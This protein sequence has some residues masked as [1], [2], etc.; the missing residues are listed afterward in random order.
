M[1]SFT[2]QW[3]LRCRLCHR[4]TSLEDCTNY[5]ECVEG[6][7]GGAVDDDDDGGSND[8]NESGG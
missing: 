5:E 6:Q 2:A 3:Y 8:D 4:A 1:F 7:V